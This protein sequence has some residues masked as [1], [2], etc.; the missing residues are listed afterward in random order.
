MPLSDPTVT[1]PYAPSAPGDPGSSPLADANVIS[2]PVQAGVAGGLVL[3]S[4]GDDRLVLKPGD[5]AL[6]NGGDDVFVLTTHHPAGGSEYLGSIFDFGPGD[7]LDLS[8]LGEKAHILGEQA[9]AGGARV[10]I[11]YNGDGVEDGYVTLGSGVNMPTPDGPSA[12]TSDLATPHAAHD[13]SAG[14]PG[15]ELGEHID[16]T[17]IFP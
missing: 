14:F 3:G 5:A 13:S 8:Q 4:A 10:S 6:G 9:G 16:S 1:L 2:G 15:L 17:W 11:D 7:R 12:A